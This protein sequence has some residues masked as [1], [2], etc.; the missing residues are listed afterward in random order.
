MDLKNYIENLFEQN[1]F[2]RSLGIVITALSEGHAEGEITIN[3]AHLNPQKSVHGGCI[4]S[5]ID[6]IGGAAA[7]MRG[8]AIVTSHGNIIY[9]N[10]AINSAKII[11][12]ATEVK[13]G[14]TLMIYDI[15]VFNEKGVHL[16]KS[17]ITF[18]RFSEVLLNG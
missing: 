13:L 9:T 18:F 3:E 4:F 10:P 7:A 8:N 14:K 2:I 12:V 6:T 11:A 5:L 1:T 15:D 16:A 17:T